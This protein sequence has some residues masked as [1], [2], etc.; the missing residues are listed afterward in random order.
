MGFGRWVW[1]HDRDWRQFPDTSLPNCQASG[2]HFRFPDNGFRLD[3]LVERTGS[4]NIGRK[5]SVVGGLLLA[6]TIML[7]NYVTSNRH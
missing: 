5:L 4:A 6:A 2:V 1:Q 7:A 3:K